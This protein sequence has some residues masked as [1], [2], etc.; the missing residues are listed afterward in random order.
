[1]EIMAYIHKGTWL[2]EDAQFKELPVCVAMNYNAT[3]PGGP[4]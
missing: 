4:N 1:M 3:K 2:L